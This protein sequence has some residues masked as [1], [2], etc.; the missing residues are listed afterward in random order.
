[1]SHVIRGYACY[2]HCGLAYIQGVCFRICYWN[3]FLQSVH[4]ATVAEKKTVGDYG[5]LRDLRAIRYDFPPSYQNVP[6]MTPR[7]QI[8]VGA[9]HSIQ[10]IVPLVLHLHKV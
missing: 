8:T 5:E 2:D 4:Q 7:T 9:K 6:H 10:D 1:M 3:I